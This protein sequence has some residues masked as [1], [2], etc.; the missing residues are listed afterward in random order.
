MTI[1]SDFYLLID[2]GARREREMAALTVETLIELHGIFKPDNNTTPFAGTFSFSNQT[3]VS[4]N[5]VEGCYREPAW[6][7]YLQEFPWWTL[8][9]LVPTF[10]FV[11][12]LGNMQP[13]KT[14]ELPVMVLIS[15]ASFAANT[16]ANAYI[17]DR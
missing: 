5:I 11:S 1:G 7:W 17:F 8:F 16:A 9:I 10:S 3:S 6:P 15:C 4:A 13:L 2:S 14:K 12:S